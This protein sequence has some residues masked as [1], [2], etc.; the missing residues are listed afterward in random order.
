MQRVVKRVGAASMVLVSDQIWCSVSAGG[1]VYS[2]N[3]PGASNPVTRVDT[4]VG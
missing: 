2:Q 4:R 1:S 3:A